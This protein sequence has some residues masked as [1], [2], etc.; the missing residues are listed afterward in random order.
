MS[1]TKHTSLKA[2]EMIVLTLSIALFFQALSLLV[3]EKRAL[4]N[5]SSIDTLTRLDQFGNVDYAILKLPFSNNLVSRKDN[6][7]ADE[8]ED[9]FNTRDVDKGDSFE[10][11]DRAYAK[12][13]YAEAA[14][15]IFETM[16]SLQQTLPLDSISKNWIK[17]ALERTIYENRNVQVRTCY[18]FAVARM[19]DNDLHCIIGD[20]NKDLRPINLMNCEVSGLPRMDMKDYTKFIV[21]RDSIMKYLG[22]HFNNAG[23]YIFRPGIKI[24]I[25]GSLF[26]DTDHKAGTIGPPLHRPVTA[27]EIHPISD[28][29]FLKN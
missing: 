17:K 27:W 25:S 4:D 5:M 22:S 1:I 12:L 8:T 15:Q 3:P 7:D 20:Y 23:Y 19:D 26:F 9:G 6:D 16:G 21:V 13:S 18:L 29:T 14:P 28:I 11:S 2:V 10:G 24:A